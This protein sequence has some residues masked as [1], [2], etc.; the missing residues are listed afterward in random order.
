MFLDGGDPIG[1]VGDT[2]N[3]TAAGA[4]AFA[5]GPESDEGGF[6]FTGAS[7]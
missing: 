4:T 5:A 1:I 7:L 3:L 6:S 2:I